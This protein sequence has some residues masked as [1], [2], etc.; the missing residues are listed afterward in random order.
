MKKLGSTILLWAATF[1]TAQYCWGGTYSDSFPT[2][3]NPTYWSVVQTI[4]NFY[5]VTLSSNQV[6]L[7]NI[8]SSNPGGVQEVAVRLDLSQ[9]GGSISNDFTVSVQFSDAVIPG[10]GLDQVELHTFYQDG[11]IY[12]TS[13]DNSS[14]LNAHVWDG[15]SSV[16][17][18][19]LSTNGGL[20]TISRTG[21]STTG[22]FNGTP[23]YSETRTSAVDAIE[24]TSQNN[25]GS[26]DPISV[27]FG[28]FSLSSSSVATNGLRTGS[29]SFVNFTN[30]ANFT[31]AATDSVPGEPLGIREAGAPVGP[32]TLSGVPF[33]IASSPS[34]KQAWHADVAANGGS[35]VVSL[36][37]Y[38]GIYGVTNA[39][40]MINTWD[41]QPGPTAYA[42]FVFTG[43]GGTVYTNY[44]VGGVDICDYNHGPW[45]NALTSSNTIN[46]FRC[47]DDNWGN[48]GRLD[49]QQMALPSAFATQI[50][51]SVQL[52][53]NGGPALQRVILDA[54]TLQS[55]SSSPLTISRNG[56]QVQ[57]A[58]PA[59]SGAVLQTNG[60]LAT[61]NWANYGGPVN[62]L[63]T[64]NIVTV[65]PQAKALFFRLNLP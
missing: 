47:L 24:F 14:G 39:Y 50:L 63:G 8:G 55:A 51:A 56:N 26:S 3:L 49:M 35:G 10:P 59:A 48:P 61:A 45:E 1:F 18:L 17:T 57:V 44:L 58:W 29:F 34:G 53:D 28:N 38:P 31:Y 25:G 43:S 13:Y 11:S 12:F 37:T 4:T 16:G 41:G 62:I 2:G 15:S 19:P 20:F 42:W 52:I 7:A 54:L 22:Y 60:N 46:V 32:V 5:T 27:T 64:S 9:L 65:A 6:H 36:I 23:L 40:S 21:S 30:Q 33:N